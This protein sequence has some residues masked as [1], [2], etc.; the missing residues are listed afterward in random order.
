MRGHLRGNCEDLTAF[1]A[2]CSRARGRALLACWVG[3]CSRRELLRRLLRR[4]SHSTGRRRSRCTSMAARGAVGCGSFAGLAGSAL[5]A[6][7]FGHSSM[8][9]RLRGAWHGLLEG[10]WCCRRLHDAAH[11]HLSYRMPCEDVLH[12]GAKRK[13]VP[14][15]DISIRRCPHIDDSGVALR[16]VQSS[17]AYQVQWGGCNDRRR[18]S[19]LG[20]GIPRFPHTRATGLCRH[21]VAQKSPCGVS[22]DCI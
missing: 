11:E 8:R 13:K 16:R 20:V 12:K 4:S 17:R 7:L 6:A 15:L 2:T 18:S 14:P 1:G 19:S 3:R 10:T 22:M 21:C 5:R 9:T